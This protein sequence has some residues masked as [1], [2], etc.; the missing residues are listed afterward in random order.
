M[1]SLSVLIYRTYTAVMAV[2]QYGT[3]KLVS[4]GCSAT[5][6]LTQPIRCILQCL[7]TNIWENGSEKSVH[8]AIWVEWFE[9]FS[10]VTLGLF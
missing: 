4:S 3:E 1:V 9:G 6:N 7:E 10:H 2:V 8:R 5:T